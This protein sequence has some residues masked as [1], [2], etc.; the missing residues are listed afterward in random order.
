M[1]WLSSLCFWPLAPE[2][3][4]LLLDVSPSSQF[5]PPHTVLTAPVPRTRP[6]NH[7]ASLLGRLPAPEDAEL[8]HSHSSNHSTASSRPLSIVEYADRRW[9]ERR[10]ERQGRAR[11]REAESR[12][13]RALSSA[14]GSRMCKVDGH[15]TSQPT[16]P[17]FVDG[18]EAPPRPPSATSTHSRA[19]Q[20]SM[21]NRQSHVRHRS[22]DV[23]PLQTSITDIVVPDSPTSFAQSPSTTPHALPSPPPAFSTRRTVSTPVVP[24]PPTSPTTPPQGGPAGGPPGAQQ[25]A[26]DLP[27]LNHLRSDSSLTTLNTLASPCAVRASLPLEEKYRASR[28]ARGSMSSVSDARSPSPHPRDLVD[29]MSE[30]DGYPFPHPN[31]YD[32]GETLYDADDSG[33]VHK[34]I[35]LAGLKP[36]C[37]TGST[38]RRKHNKRV[39]FPPG[40]ATTGRRSRA[41]SKASMTFGDYEKVADEKA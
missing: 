2:R 34:T 26:A 23:L 6:F 24:S 13:Q 20:G 16:T 41:D 33:V 3:Q 9:E 32:E 4:P 10:E 19:T 18:R 28:A 31:E 39:R 14:Y 15:R 30:A 38:R 12:R 25:V 5:P 11:R 17:T 27:G 8:R 35:G 36:I 40:T 21:G 37:G 29:R 7:L 1:S 22:L